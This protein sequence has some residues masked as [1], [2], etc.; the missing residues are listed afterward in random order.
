[1][2]EKRS[3][4]ERYPAVSK[5][6]EE[7]GE[8]LYQIDEVAKKVGL[9]VSTLRNYYR[10][11]RTKGPSFEL[12]RGDRKVLFYTDADIEEIMRLQN[13]ELKPRSE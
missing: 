5:Y 9:S 1:M 3:S 6:W 11:S 8:S 13:A 10:N 2:S 4:F 7:T 12:T